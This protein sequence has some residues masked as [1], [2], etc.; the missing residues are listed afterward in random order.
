MFDYINTEVKPDVA[1]WGG[2]SVPYLH[3]HENKDEIGESLSKAT[4]QVVNGLPDI[5][6][7]VTLGNLDTFP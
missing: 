6:T 4:D 2:D 5:Q 3:G 7:Y 1:F